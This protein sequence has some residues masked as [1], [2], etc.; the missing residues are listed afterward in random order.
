MFRM[1][2]GFCTREAYKLIDGRDYMTNII[3]IIQ[4]EGKTNEYILQTR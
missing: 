4:K 3:N 2:S 1:P